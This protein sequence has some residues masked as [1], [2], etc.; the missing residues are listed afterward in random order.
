M[1]CA[2]LVVANQ[3]EK[4]D[5][6]HVYQVYAYSSLQLTT[7]V[8]TINISCRDGLSKFSPFLIFQHP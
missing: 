7:L 1:A 3:V 6:V 8:R 4:C 2:L 5:N